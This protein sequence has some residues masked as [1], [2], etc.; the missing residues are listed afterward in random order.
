MSLRGGRTGKRPGFSSL[1]YK[2]G[3]SALYPFP[4]GS[5]ARMT[6]GSER[7]ATAAAV[8]HPVKIG[9]APAWQSWGRE[10]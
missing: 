10:V 1:L 4:E 9:F 3:G 6:P 8:T 2:R 7:N 5:P